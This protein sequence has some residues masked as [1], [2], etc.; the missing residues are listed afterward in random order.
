[1]TR[2]R[3]LSL[4]GFLVLGFAR[5]ATADELDD[6][7]RDFWAWRAVEQP[8]SGDDIPRIER[9]ADWI[10]VWSPTAIDQRRRAL[11]AFEGRWAKLNPSSW[12]VSRQVDYRL[13][14]SALA[15]VRWELEVT[16]G[17]QRNPMFYVEQT[18]GAI[19][20]RLL[21]PAPLD[22]VRTE[23]ILKRMASIPRTV[24]DAK[25]NLFDP[26][27]PFARLALD[28]LKDV[29]PRLL[30]VVRGLKPYLAADSARDL[31]A[32]TNRAGEALE[33]YRSWLEQRLPSMPSETAV[34][35]DA[36]VFFLKNVALMPFTP[37]ELLEMGRQ[38]WARAVAFEALQDQR[39][40][41]LSPL[42][43]FSNQAAQI[44]REEHDEVEIRR[45]LEEKR[46]LSVPAWVK[47]Y[48]NLPL[49]AYLGPLAEM[50]VTD[51]LTSPT[52]LG[53]NGTSY[54]HAP[55]PAL[56]YFALASAHDPR[57]IIVHEGVPGHYFQLVLSWAHEDAIR[58]HY[59]DSGANEGIG[60]YAEEMMLQAGLFDES[61][62][63]RSI[64][65][66][67]MRLRALRV[68]VDVKLALGTF[69][70]D[71]AATYLRNMV[72]MDAATARSEAVSFAS[73][74]GQAI[75]Y[76]IGKLQILNF[77]A[78]A[79]RM[80]GDAFSLKAFHD[81]LW[82][83]GNVPIALQRWEYLGSKDEIEALDRMGK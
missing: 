68:E 62:R 36:Y 54:I 47:H 29:R 78:D 72:P 60:F 18:L 77:L 12:P 83:N 33:S 6:L 53:E 76:Q 16:R 37:E 2:W 74:P 58:R 15:R 48:R 59:Y 73:G 49:P 7:A 9:P 71:Q 65:Y 24:E 26:A 66:N 17:W 11:A 35:R 30:T 3:C 70:I 41:G 80:Q 23:E 20:D 51:D 5:A 22:R 61:H 1:M 42:A 19:F 40:S 82:T 67:F 10:P 81:F 44:D 25:T 69:N 43:L 55:S 27:A 50:G 34:G 14:G 32:A 38:E 21:R 79:R 52:R 13:I 57:P 63:T 28:A 64:I 45:F 4:I 31:E 8:I 39:N 75:S 56:G 46:I